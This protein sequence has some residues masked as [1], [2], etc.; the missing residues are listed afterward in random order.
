MSIVVIN[1]ERFH[2]FGCRV[3]AHPC[4]TLIICRGML[5]PKSG[6]GD[7]AMRRVMPLLRQRGC[8]VMFAAALA[9]GTAALAGGTAALAGGTAALAGGTAVP[10]GGAAVAGEG[11]VQNLRSYI[12]PTI[13]PQARAIY[14]KLLPIAAAHRAKEKIPH[15]LAEFDA[16]HDADI[17][18][19]VPAALAAAKAGN[20]AVR[21]LMLAGVNVV[22]ATPPHY[23]DDHTL[24]L[25]VHGG[26]FVLGSAKSSLGADVLMALATDKRV[27][28]IDYTVA[29]RG[30][31]RT[32]TDQVVAVYQA[33]LAQGYSARSIGLFGDSAGGN[34]VAASVFKLRDRGLPLPGALVLLSPCV[35]FHLNGDTETTLREADPVLDFALNQAFLA[36][37]AAPDQWNNPYVSPIHGDFSK[38]YPPVLIQAGTKEL[39]L[40]DAV[41]LYQAVKIAGGTAELDVYEGM[42]HVFQAY[43]TGTPE[44]AAAYA[45]ANRWWSSHLKPSI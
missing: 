5:A 31:W 4:L 33:V 37:Y 25:H 24:L 38:G 16:R 44:Q 26:G 15:T 11:A 18:R 39:L 45:E 42:A 29:P 7:M 14:E 36:T 20:V 41:R 30:N 13:S 6:Q 22:E 40:S 3:D 19:T 8:A 17:A 27:I 34:I 23:R 35:D 10:V 43:M 1:Y 21:E 9:G 32:V 12:P 2:S 28:S